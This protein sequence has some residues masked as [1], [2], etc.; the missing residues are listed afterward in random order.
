MQMA[1]GYR[2]AFQ[3]FLTVSKGL[4]LQGSFTK[5]QSRMLPLYMNIGRYLK[6]GQI[7]RKEIYNV[8]S[9]YS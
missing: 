3:M 2:D 7:L 4:M 8:K 1:P 6:L 9:G 5:C